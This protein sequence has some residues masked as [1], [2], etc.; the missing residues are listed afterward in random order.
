M[1]ITTHIPVPSPTAVPIP[2]LT[3]TPVPT[4]SGEASAVYVKELLKTNA[5]CELPCWWGIV[6][7]ETTWADAQQLILYTGARINKGTEPDGTTFYG[8]GFD[9]GKQGLYIVNLWER[10]DIVKHVEIHAEGYE[11]LS[12]FKTT[13]AYYSPENVI[14][15]RGQPSRVWVQTFA[16]AHE[17]PYGDTMG[18]NLW[19]FYDDS[20]FLVRYSGQVKYEPVYR[21]CPT[22][23]E[24]GNL[25]LSLEIYIQSFDNHTPLERAVGRRTGDPSSIRSIEDAAGLSVEEFYALFMQDERPICFETPRDIWP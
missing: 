3:L 14:A 9:L 5:G 23:E 16:S 25:G 11:S 21:M 13:A 20:G 19:L 6:A 8:T 17:L 1:P 10:A 15:I 22:F 4:L 2:T 7:G 24:N 18:Y 12:S